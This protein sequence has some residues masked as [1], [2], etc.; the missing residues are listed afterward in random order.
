MRK[1]LF[2]LLFFFGG[3]ASELGQSAGRPCAVPSSHNARRRRD[4]RPQP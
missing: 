2:S 4:T 1:L 3:L